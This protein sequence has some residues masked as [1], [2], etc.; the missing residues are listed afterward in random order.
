MEL[1]TVN[2]LF[3]ELSQFADAKTKRELDLEN[4]LEHF[5]NTGCAGC[6]ELGQQLDRLQKRVAFSTEEGLF[7][8]ELFDHVI[9]L[10][11]KVLK[12]L[13]EGEKVVVGSVECRRVLIPLKTI[14]KWSRMLEGEPE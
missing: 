14:E 2:K 11:E 9:G 6:T 10:L 4:Q 8:V 1:E 5:H 12:S 13:M 3:L 7:D